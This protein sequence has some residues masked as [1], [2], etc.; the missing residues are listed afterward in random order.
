[1]SEHEQLMDMLATLTH[2]QRETNDAIVSLAQAIAASVGMATAA[3]QT[4]QVIG[5]ASKTAKVA[6]VKKTEEPPPPAPEPPATKPAP[7]QES[8]G[9]EVTY[10]EA[11]EAVIAL[12]RSH[13]K[14]A[15]LAV[16]KQFGAAR[17]PEVPATQYEAVVAACC[18]AAMAVAA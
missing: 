12:Q 5:E 4:G 1:M 9:T 15:A 7:V 14:N 10:K 16:L 3:Y 18:N 2:C 17:L 13:G 6:A 8:T 11:S